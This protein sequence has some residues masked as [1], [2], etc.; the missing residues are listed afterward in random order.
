MHHNPW[1]WLSLFSAL[2]FVISLVAIPPLIARLPAD[3]FAQQERRAVDWHDQHPL[4]K[5]MVSI[6]RNVLGVILLCG[7]FIMLFI[8]GQGLLTMAV[9]LFMLDYPG[10]FK[11]ERHL[12]S[13][14]TILRGLNWIRRRYNKPP[15]IIE[16]ALQSASSKQTIQSDSKKQ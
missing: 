10:K 9:G 16:P 15:L 3:Y 8:P 5:I 13:Y 4:L 2:A 7:G 6:L 11:L 14:P 12:V 1:L